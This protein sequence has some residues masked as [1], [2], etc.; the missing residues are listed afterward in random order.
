MTAMTDISAIR[1]FRDECN[2]VGRLQRH[3]VRHG[4]SRHSQLRNSHSAFVT[5]VSATRPRTS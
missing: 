3:P 2:Q 5:T 1:Q 4:R